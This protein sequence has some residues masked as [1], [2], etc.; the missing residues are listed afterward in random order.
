MRPITLLRIAAAAIALTPSSIAASDHGFT[1]IYYF[2][3]P[4]DGHHDGDYPTALTSDSSGNIYGTTAEG[5]SNRGITGSGCGTIFKITPNGKK[6]TVHTFTCGNG[7]VPLGNLVVDSAGNIFGTTEEGGHGYRWC[8]YGCGTVY[9]VGPGGNKVLH[10][11]GKNAS[12]SFPSSGVIM[13]SSGNLYGTTPFNVFMLSSDGYHETTLY[14][15]RKE[16]ESYPNA[17]VMDGGGNLYGTTEG[18]IVFSLAPDRQLTVLH[19]FKGTDDGRYPRAGVVLDGSGSLY[20]TTYS[21]GGY[22]DDGTV[23]RIDSD[24]TETVLHDFSGAPYDGSR[25]EAALLQDSDGNLY[26]TTSVG[27]TSDKGAVFELARDGEETLLHSFK[28]RDGASPVASLI[29]ANGYLYGTTEA[30]GNTDCFEGC[31][32]VFRL[33]P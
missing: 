11:F 13:D 23:Y 7:S 17:L 8:R 22:G 9:E 6:S 31:G 21:G 4:Y 14:R 24:G 25:P 33:K 26:G 16:D 10:Y 1:T 19:H 32:T 15:F 29:F 20:G 3:G 18:G 27:G 12:A 30:G 2:K 28:G 5:G